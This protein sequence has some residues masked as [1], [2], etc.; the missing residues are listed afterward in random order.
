MATER[1]SMRM[2]REILRQ[3]WALAR[4]VRAVAASVGR[5]VGAIHATERRAKAAGLAW[6]QIDGL[7]DEALEAALYR[8][9]TMAGPR[10]ERAA[11]DCA[12]LHTERR[13]PGVTLQL[14]HV[15]YLEQHPDGYRYTQFCEQYR[16]WLRRRR[17]SMRQVHRA[18]EKGFV[19]Y[20]GKTPWLTDPRTGERDPG[21]EG[22]EQSHCHSLPTASRASRANRCLAGTNHQDAAPRSPRESRV[23]TRGLRSPAP[24]LPASRSALRSADA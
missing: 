22:E 12:Y 6:A 4:P 5:S 19:D 10:R 21:E 9:P 16:T 24:S 3:R 13:K 7:T 1:L 18:G 2:M 23:P 20:A 15:E 8:R 14:L 17:L 11:P